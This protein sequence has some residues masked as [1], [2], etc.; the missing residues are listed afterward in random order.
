[1]AGV[2]SEEANADAERYMQDKKYI[3][4]LIGDN[5]RIVQRDFVQTLFQMTK[6]PKSGEGIPVFQN[7]S[8]VAKF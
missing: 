5:S 4:T 1:L 2:F 3:M 6:Q 7:L 8:R